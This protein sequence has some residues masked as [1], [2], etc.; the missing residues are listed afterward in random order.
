MP[1]EIP[2]EHSPAITRALSAAFGVT[3]FEDIRPI[4]KGNTD[5]LIYRIVVRGQ[6]YLLRIVVRRNKIISHEREFICMKAAAEAGIAPRVHY[7]NLEDQLSISDFIEE[8]P[9]DRST[10]LRQIPATLRALHALPPF[11]RV[12]AG[13]DTTCMSLVSGGPVIEGFLQ[14]F[15]ESCA[16]PPAE[17]EYLLASHA[18]IAAVYPRDA[19]MVSSHNDL[20]KPD[21]IL[22]DGRVHLVDW[23]AAFLNDRFADLAVV[24]NQIVDSDAEEAAFLNA[25]FQRAP[26]PRETARFYLARQLA[27]VFYTLAFVMMGAMGQP[28]DL[29]SMP[30]VQDLRVRMWAGKCNLADKDT[31]LAF[32]LSHWQQLA[33]RDQVR[34]NESLALLTP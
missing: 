25:Y 29:N 9:L 30:D 21:N 6:P 24:G 14:K 32:G 2:Q 12:V 11:P 10:A 13:F 23:E 20:F 1:T 33:N 27:H 34:W 15:R 7:S 17:T 5:A 22:Y 28:V 3:G 16:L 31:K 4:T 8:V 26:T 18:Q 19:D